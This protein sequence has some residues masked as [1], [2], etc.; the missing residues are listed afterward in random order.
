MLAEGCSTSAPPPIISAPE[1]IETTCKTIGARIS[2]DF[3]GAPPSR[4][5]IEGER[6]FS[7]LITPE[8]SPPINPSPWFAFRYETEGD[9][10]LTIHLRYLG[11][12]HR[13]PPRWSDGTSSLLLPVELSADRK[14][15]TFTAPAG[16][17]IISGQEIFDGTRHQ[18]AI[19]RWS[20]TAQSGVI[21]LGRSHDG[22]PVEAVRLG[23]ADAPR[24]V[25]LLGR[26][27]PPEV[28][29][30]IAMEAFVDRIVELLAA[31]PEL[32]KS[33][34][35]L[36]VPLLNPDGV[37][38]GHWRANLGGKDL[39]R[40]WGV[41]S[42]PETQSVKRWLDA[43]PETISPILMLDFHSTHRNL[44]YVQD[45]SEASE[46]K[47][48]LTAWLLGKEESMPGYPFSI[49]RRD[50]SSGDG[51]TRFWFHSVYGIPAY[52]YEVADDADREAARAAARLLATDLPRALSA[53]LSN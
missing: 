12:D 44:F 38:R 34:Q 6:E 52:T 30:A 17:A 18:N 9:Q 27:H 42:Q 20:A 50:S 28:T 15:A 8:H 13:Y 40:D 24:L 7:V 33:Y 46:T 36:V 26:Q 37:A 39:N 3:E 48:F 29:G 23:Q 22:R 43:L 32:G 35:F 14:T 2:F 4:C 45:E 31:N 11:G 5:V 21:T 16:K 51:T 10:G 25:V 53:A 41:F 1:V 47:P 49:E 19:R